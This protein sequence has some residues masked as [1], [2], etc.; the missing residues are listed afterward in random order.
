MVAHIMLCDAAQVTGGKLYILGG[1]VAL[2]G[3]KPQPVAVA[4]QVLIPWDR[5]N[6]GHH[7]RV[8][9]IDEDGHL[10]THRDRPIVAEGRFEVGRPA[11]VRPG[12]PLPMA[13]AINLPGLVLPGGRAY[14]FRLTIEGDTRPDWKAGF[15]T[16]AAPAS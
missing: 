6:I 2:I 7:W 1:G 5:A 3:P 8:E 13:L 14:E 15:A 9:L 4:V 11:G 12:T 16:R 10:V